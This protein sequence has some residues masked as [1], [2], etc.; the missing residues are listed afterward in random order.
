MK[1]STRLVCLSHVTNVTGI[2]Q[3]VASIISACRKSNPDALILVDAA[4]SVGHIPVDVNAL[5]CVIL[6]ASG[7]KGLLGPL[8]TGFVYLSERA[9]LEMRPV[10]FGGTGTN[11]ESV[12][13]PD[14]IPER[15]ESGNLNVGGIAGLLQGVNFVSTFGLEKVA[16]Q[17]HSLADRLIDAL[18]KIDSVQLYGDDQAKRTGVVSFNILDQ[19]PQTV[20]TILDAEFSIQ[21]R[22][23][24]HCAPLM[25]QALGTDTVGGSLRAS[26]GIFNSE[27]DIERLVDAITQIAG[28]L[29]R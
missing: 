22:A 17:E 18:R 14:S 13:Q 26:F 11:S 24:F 5:G 2:Q 7:H 28:Q 25:H 19:D 8:G 23:G 1:G 10:R 21:L 29:V 20:A 4:Q 12:F 6:V 3:D 27:N 15:F 9:A 16:A